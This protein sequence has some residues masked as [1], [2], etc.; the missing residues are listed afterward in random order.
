[1]IFNTMTITGSLVQSVKSVFL[2][3]ILLVAE[4]I[5]AKQHKSG[6]YSRRSV[7]TCPSRLGMSNVTLRNVNLLRLGI[8]LLRLGMYIT[9]HAPHAQKS[10]A[11]VPSGR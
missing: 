1:M 10:T 4:R 9:A 3:Q 2:Q 7:R 6:M 11:R 8:N 5:S